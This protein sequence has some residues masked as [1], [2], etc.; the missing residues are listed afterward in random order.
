MV[1]LEQKGQMALLVW[2]IYTL[3]PVHTLH[4]CES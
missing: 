4:L 1:E 2:I 3:P